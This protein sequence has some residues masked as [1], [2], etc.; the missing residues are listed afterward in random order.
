MEV[1]AV[2][3]VRKWETATK[4]ELGMETYYSKWN[5]II[6]TVSVV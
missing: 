5:I 4:E 3:S 1:K 2:Q 6:A